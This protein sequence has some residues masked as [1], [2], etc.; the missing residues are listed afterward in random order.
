MQTLILLAAEEEHE[1]NPL[2]PHPIEIVLSLV[3][4]GLLFL[5]VKKFVVP[6][7]EKTF[8]E[9]TSGD[10]G[11]P[12]RG[13]DE[14]GRGRRQ[15][16]RA[17]EAARRRPARGGAHPRG[18]ARAGRGDR[19][20]DARAGPGRVRRASSSTA[21]PRSRPSASRRSPRCGPRSARLATALAGRI[22]GESLEDDERVQTASSS[23]SSPTSRP[24]SLRD[25][26]ERRRSPLMD[27]RGP[28]AE[29]SA[30]AWQASWW[31][32]SP[33]SAPA[34]TAQVGEDL[35]GARRRC[36]VRRRACA[37]WSPTSSV[38]PRRKAAAGARALRAA[39]STRSPLDLLADGGRAPVDGHP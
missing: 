38:E 29:S 22:V 24:S 20:R 33:R 23:G 16:R 39:R 3:V 32:R 12:G 15:A 5:A 8:A 7:F 28:S 37:G 26:R 36:C 11:W 17:R 27:M 35:F 25:R 14:A 2:V 13:R 6:N 21:R 30:D 9:R 4:F 34:T 10:R 1:L 31:R 18:G 19:R